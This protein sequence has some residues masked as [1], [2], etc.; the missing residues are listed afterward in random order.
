M[1]TL[2]SGIWR[3]PACMHHQPWFSSKRELKALD[4]RCSKCSERTRVL[5]ERSGSGQG[6]TSDARVWIRHEAD[7][8]ALFREAGSRNNALKG[9]VGEVMEEQSDL[10]LIWGV[11]WRPEAALEF[12]KPLTREVIRS[13]I[14]RFVT[15]RWEGHLNMVASV[16]DSNLP[17]KS[18]DGDDFHNWSDTILKC[19]Y[20]ALTNVCTV[21]KS[22]VFWKWRLYPAEMAEHIY[23]DVDLDSYWIFD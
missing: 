2:S 9:A 3:C 13:E 8:D 16:L 12:S 20:E 6:R 17:T 10:P 1:S 23:Q 18:M 14:L 15:E 21:L 19:F 11:N 5:I 22:R 7:E 4:R